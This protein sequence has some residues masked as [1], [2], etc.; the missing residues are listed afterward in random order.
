MYNGRI[1]IV[2]HE[3][4]VSTLLNKRL[5]NL[6]YEIF[7]CNNGGDALVTFN[8]KVPDLIILEI[9]VPN[10]N[11]YS[12][13]QKIRATSQVPIIILTGVT[14]T[15]DRIA[16]MEFNIA[17]YITKPFSPKQLEAR[18]R[19]LL[20]HSD[21]NLQKPL[22]KKR[23]RLQIG[24]L[25]I[26]LQ[27]QKIVKDQ[28][29]LKLTAIEYNLLEFLIENS[30]TNLSRGIILNK[31][32]GYTPERSIDTRIVDVHISRLRSKIEKNPRKPDLILTIRGIG[33][34]FQRY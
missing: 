6:G 18:I 29:K 14:N 32:W 28:K 1:L 3:V 27:T 4:E 30:G 21:I 24:N 13:L 26:D 9:M 20:R 19:F 23:K 7:I 8:A 17:E 12:L 22:N 16:C 11:G 2:D 34:M 25:T 10:F 31:I 33:Y 5:T 15:L